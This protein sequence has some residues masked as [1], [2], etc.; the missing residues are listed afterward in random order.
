[1]TRTLPA[2]PYAILVDGPNLLYGLRAFHRGA[3]NLGDALRGLKTHF[4]AVS[5]AVM[6]V[7]TDLA[8]RPSIMRDIATNGFEAR[9]VPAGLDLALAAEIGEVAQTTKQIALVSSDADFAVPVSAA[10]RNGAAVTV[11]ALTPRLS[12]QLAATGAEVIDIIEMLVAA[13]RPGEIRIARPDIDP[14]DAAFLRSVSPQAVRT[15]RAIQAGVTLESELRR[16]CAKHGI[17]VPHAAGISVMNDA[18]LKQ[19]IYPKLTHKKV[20]VWA[21]IRNNAAHG[22]PPQ[23]TNLDIRHMEDGVREFIRTHS[24]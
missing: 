14:E 23:Y 22:L 15:L 7:D 19:G 4:G 9:L 18:L 5:R 3:R 21:E 8:R 6:F 24:S 16:L 12:Q 10:L 1:M 13:S 2:M 20:S 17:R 11:V